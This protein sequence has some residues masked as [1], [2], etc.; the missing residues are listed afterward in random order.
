MNEPAAGRGLLACD[1][2][3]DHREYLI[4]ATKG[5]SVK[6][7]AAKCPQCNG[8]L[9]LPEDKDTV[10]C[11]YC[12]TEIIIG[13]IKEKSGPNVANL[14]ELASHAEQAQ[15]YA[16]AEMYFSRVLEIE[17]ERYEVWLGKGEAAAWQSTLAAYRGDELLVGSK[18]AV[19]VAGEVGGDEVERLKMLCAVKILN[20][21]QSYHALSVDHTIQFIGVPNAR[22]EHWDRCKKIL[23]LCEVALEY[24]S[25]LNSI[26][27]FGVDVCNRCLNVSMIGAEDRNF[28]ENKRHFF[29]FGTKENKENIG[30][31][32]GQTDS[33]NPILRQIISLVVITLISYATTN[34]ALDAAGTLGRVFF[35][36][37]SGGLYL[38]ALLVLFAIVVS[39][40][41]S[42][43]GKA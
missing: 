18:K 32:S 5:S 39:V 19:K 26:K 14:L 3:V 15:N 38:L 6:F 40:K 21:A 1:D 16:E 24:H 20:F 22:Y 8:D 10:M 17:P 33:D 42:S 28:F 25:D 9:Q 29:L 12:G 37:I 13:N 27:S 34:A 2:V 36:L 7:F 31:Q 35:W 23:N 11:M 41:S 4:N 43:S 30:N